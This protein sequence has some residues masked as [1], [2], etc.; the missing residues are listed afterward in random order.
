MPH[1]VVEVLETNVRSVVIAA[2]DVEMAKKR[3]LSMTDRELRDYG[4]QR[5]H[6]RAGAVEELTPERRKAA[7]TEMVRDAEAMGLY[8][9]VDER[10]PG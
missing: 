1:Y 6:W 2:E 5:T 8:D 4:V 9:Q 7:L 10:E 3:A